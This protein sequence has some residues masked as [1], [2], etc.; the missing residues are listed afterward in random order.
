MKR[1][2]QAVRA[3]ATGRFRPPWLVYM[4][5]CRIVARQSCS[6][7]RSRNPCRRD[8]PR[9]RRRSRGY[10]RRCSRGRNDR[11]QPRRRGASALPSA[12]RNRADAARHLVRSRVAD[13][14]AVHH[15]HDPAPRGAGTHRS[16][17][18]ADRGAFRTCGSTTATRRSGSSRSAN[19]SAT[20]PIC[21]P[22]SRS[23]PTDRTRRRCAPSSCSASGGRPAGLF[24]H[25]F[26]PAGHCDRAADRTA[27][28]D[29]AAAGLDLAS[30]DRPRPRQPSAAPGAA[31]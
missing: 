30:A 25:Q 31:A 6:R 13:Q 20:R 7:D 4:A 9:R 5:L 23:T 10:P 11:R 3:K 21:P 18:P 24:R 19:A 22:S 17:R 15:A 12:N 29:R 14:G 2:H 28:C 16:R 1:L 26:H 8:R 27:R